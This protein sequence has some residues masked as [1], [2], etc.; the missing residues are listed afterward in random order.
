MDGG[1]RKIN[2]RNI[3]SDD[4]IR[5]LLEYYGEVNCNNDKAVIR[6]CVKRPIDAFLQ[7]P[8]VMNIIYRYC[9]IKDNRK[10]LDNSDSDEESHCLC[11]TI[12]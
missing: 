2:I 9:Y 6:F 3:L 4:T 8:E 10:D 12:S 5:S 1:D 11:C 7:V